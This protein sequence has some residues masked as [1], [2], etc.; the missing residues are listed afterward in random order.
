MG[1]VGGIVVFLIVWW[2]VFFA[3]LPWGVVS[4]AEHDA[5]EPGTDPGAPTRPA[6]GRKALITTTI[7]ACLWLIIYIVIVNGLI[8]LELRPGAPASQ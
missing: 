1:L 6:L 5:V 3:V 4:Q 2:M 7:A 8:T